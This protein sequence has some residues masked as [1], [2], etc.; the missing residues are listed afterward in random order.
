VAD[1]GSVGNSLMA[2]ECHAIVEVAK[3]GEG[4]GCRDGALIA[5]RDSVAR[6]R[7]GRRSGCVDDPLRQMLAEGSSSPSRPDSW[8]FSCIRVYPIRKRRSWEHEV[9]R[10][11]REIAPDSGQ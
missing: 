4:P 10:R 2:H 8:N 7:R 5:G 9:R 3:A 11:A 6:L 1:D